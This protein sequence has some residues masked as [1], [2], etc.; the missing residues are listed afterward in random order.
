MTFD[1]S[2]NTARRSFLSRLAAAAAAF[3][4][5]GAP[6]SASAER[7]DTSWPLAGAEDEPWMQKLSGSQRVIFH[8]HEATNGQALTWARSYLDSQKANYGRADKESSV[9]VGL[10]GKAVGLVF[11]DAMWAKYPIG[12][13]LN[14]PGTSNPNAAAVAQL[15]SRGA[16]VL[17]C[18]NSLRAAGQRFLP[19]PARSDA[20]ARTAFA[21]EVRASLLPG[22]EIVPA[23]VTTLQMAQD[24]GCRYIYAGG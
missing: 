4:V 2:I 18:S 12:Q 17:V 19:E 9:V 21:E 16:I 10:N 24:R 22:M 23:M 5:V 15:L 1:P 14:M 13:T 20:A 11:S 7:P 6:T 3:G 8:S